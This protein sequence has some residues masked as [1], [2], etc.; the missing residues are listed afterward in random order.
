MLTK[1]LQLKGWQHCAKVQDNIDTVLPLF[2]VRSFQHGFKSLH[3]TSTL[4]TTVS[5]SVLEGLNHGKPALRSLVAA[6][7]ISKAFDT[8]PQYKLV[9]KILD[10]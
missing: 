9:S 4:L 6:M 7:D 8:V 1:E 10:T 2:P 5:P 3:S